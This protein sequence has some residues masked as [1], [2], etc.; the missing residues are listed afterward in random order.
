V[1]GLGST[2]IVQQSTIL[3]LLTNGQNSLLSAY[4]LHSLQYDITEFI[5]VNLI[6][7][8]L[9]CHVSSHKQG[10]YCGRKGTNIITILLHFLTLEAHKELNLGIFAIVRGCLLD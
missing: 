8:S 6:R 9:I 7:I 5:T 4:N 1:S 3:T 10:I 2:G